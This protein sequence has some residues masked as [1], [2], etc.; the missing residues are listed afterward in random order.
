M[1]TVVPQEYLRALSPALCRRDELLDGVRR[2][3]R[4][5]RLLHPGPG[6]VVRILHHRVTDHHSQ[7]RVQLLVAVPNGTRT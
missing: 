1:V 7:L 5:H 4:R 2:N 6:N 3:P